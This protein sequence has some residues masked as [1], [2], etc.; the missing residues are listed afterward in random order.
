[1]LTL[2]SQPRGTLLILFLI[3]TKSEYVKVLK[4]LLVSCASFF[5]NIAFFQS[6]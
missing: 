1:M 5:N 3:L 2:R 6:L 4:F